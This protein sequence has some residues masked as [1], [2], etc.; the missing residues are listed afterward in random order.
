M[1]LISARVFVYDM[2]RPTLNENRYPGSN[3]RIKTPAKREPT[4]AAMPRPMRWRS[5]LNMRCSASI[6][7]TGQPTCLSCQIAQ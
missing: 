2:P 3:T 1:A 5:F 6:A 4:S 7:T